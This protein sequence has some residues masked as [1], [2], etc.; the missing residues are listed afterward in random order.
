MSEPLGE[1]LTW[2]T[3]P[4]PEFLPFPDVMTAFGSGITPTGIGVPLGAVAAADADGDGDAASA[5][6]R[7]SGHHQDEQRRHQRDAQKP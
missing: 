5:D 6:G 4:G 2:T 7:Q 3:V 1:K